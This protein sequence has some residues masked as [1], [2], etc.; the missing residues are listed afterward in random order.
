MLSFSRKTDYGLVALTRLAEAHASGGE[1]ISARQIAGEF[2]GM[3]LPL[4]MNV[5]K[6]LQRAGI[7]TSTRGSR[8]GYV[9]AQPPQQI[10]VARVVGAI[11]GPLQITMCCN[12]HEEPAEEEQD[13]EC[14][15]LDRCPVSPA[16]QRLQQ[17]VNQFFADVTLQDIC[18][19]HAEAPATGIGV[20]TV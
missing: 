11:E 15:L 1:P 2:H 10:S 18:D 12:G 7:V 20:M 19:A 3:P 5:L 8:G 6:D 14:R 4:L 9:L 16:I 17:R 13:C